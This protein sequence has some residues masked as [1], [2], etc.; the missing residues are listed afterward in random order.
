MGEKNQAEVQR[1]KG[2]SCGLA[3]QLSSRICALHVQNLGPIPAQTHQKETP[4]N[5]LLPSFLIESPLCGVNPFK[6]VSTSNVQITKQSFFVCVV[7]FLDIGGLCCHLLLVWVLKIC[8]FEAESSYVA[9]AG[10]ELVI[11]PPQP[12]QYWHCKHM[13]P[14]H[15]C[16]EMHAKVTECV[17]HASVREPPGR[18]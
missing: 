14:Y 10:L 9:Q 7:L 13:A 6:S 5:P 1:I 11:L 16:L 3:V 2:S 12:L 4:P 8:T 17:T 18:K 15:T